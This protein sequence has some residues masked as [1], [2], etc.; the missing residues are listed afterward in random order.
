MKISFQIIH[1]YQAEP[2]KVIAKALHLTMQ[3]DLY[4]QL[5]LRTTLDFVKIT[6]SK[7]LISTDNLCYF[8]ID[9]DTATYTINNY[10]DFIEGFVSRLQNEPGFIKIIKYNDEI[11]IETYLTY[12]RE[13]AEIEMKIREV[14]SYIFYSK[15]DE[16]R[17]DIF[18][19]FE[20]QI[21]NKEDVKLEELTKRFE[22][23]FFYLTFKQY[24]KF[25]TPKDIPTKEVLPLIINNQ[26]YDL[27]RDYVSSR[28][29]IE[30]KHLSFLKKVSKLL[31]PIE[32][33]RNCIA[34]NRKIP[35]NQLDN[36]PTA[37]DE[38]LKFIEDFWNEEIEI[39][40]DDFQMTLLEQGSNNKLIILLVNAIWNEEAN[41]V[42]VQDIYLQDTPTFTFDNFDEFHRYLMKTVEDDAKLGFPDFEERPEV[43]QS[44]FNGQRL[45][46]KILKEYK[47]EL[48]IMS[49]I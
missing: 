37:K 46:D 25:D 45:V 3:D 8:D 4:I 49:W 7:K 15:Y 19:E 27:L 20:V 35:N 43:F 32:N 47:K 30:Q 29:I 34:H 31:D 23:K 28:G 39:S 18:D 41:E 13:I 11:R 40:N 33:V 9:I 38:I 36:Y 42:S 44:I 6:L 12:Y 10:D 26:S 14:F 5:D 17:Q 2:L 21:V 22:N 1:N 48:I 24:L 16:K